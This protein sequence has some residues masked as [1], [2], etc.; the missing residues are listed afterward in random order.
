MGKRPAPSALALLRQMDR[1][2]PHRSH[3]SDGIVPSAAHSATN[4]ASDHEPG[5]AGYCHA[6]DVTHDPRHGADMA[7]VSR[8]IVKDSRTKY[9]I[10]RRR[11]WTPSRGWHAYSGS[12]PHTGHMHLSIKDTR[13]ACRSTRQW[14][15]VAPPKPV[16]MYVV[17]R[18][19]PDAVAKVRRRA[20]ALGQTCRGPKPSELGGV[21]WCCHSR[22]VVGWHLIRRARKL[23]CAATR[24]W[25][26]HRRADAIDRFWK[27]VK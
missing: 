26:T 27:R 11:I 20:R 7:R 18:G 6:C 3:G 17:V 12:N 2:A 19:L 21:V 16:H 25:T 8:G 15:G 14:R 10:F 1:V 5:K 9:V 13:S 22:A 4:P 24:T 23:G